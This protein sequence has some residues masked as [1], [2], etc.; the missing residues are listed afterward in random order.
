MIVKKGEVYYADLNP[1]IG[2]EQGGCRPV[3]IVQNNTGNLYSPTTIIVPVTARKR[4][5]ALPTHIKV[6]GAGLPKKSIALLEQ[7]RTIDK[8]RLKEKVGEI[9][10]YTPYRGLTA[11]RNWVRLKFDAMNLK[12]FA[13]HKDMERKRKEGSF[14]FAFCFLNYYNLIFKNQK[15]EIQLS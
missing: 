11:V 4:K 9:I 5:K 15:L 14:N 3:V 12:K 6:K 1:V 8:S 2:S 7:L 10:R 13:I